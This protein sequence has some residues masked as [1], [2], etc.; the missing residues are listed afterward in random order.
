MTALNSLVKSYGRKAKNKKLDFSLTKDEMLKLFKSNCNYCGKT[1]SQVR[2]LPNSN[3]H[4]IY[5]EID[6]VDSTKGYIR[7]NCV[8]C[9]K[10]CNTAKNTL[11][12]KKFLCLI[13]TI[14]EYNYGYMQIQ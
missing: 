6:R 13:K 11:S 9:C 7:S 14:Y 10:D 3:G 2:K 8:S 5:N 4:F 1:P 12:V